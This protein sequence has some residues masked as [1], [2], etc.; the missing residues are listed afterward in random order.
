MIATVTAAITLANRVLEQLPNYDQRKRAAYKELSETF[1][2][3][4]KK[5]YPDRDDDLIMNLRDKLQA[6]FEEIGNAKP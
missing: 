2:R 6:H 4:T 3:E 1:I 5:Q